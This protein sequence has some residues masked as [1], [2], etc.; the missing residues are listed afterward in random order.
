[1]RAELYGS[2]RIFIKKNFYNFYYSINNNTNLW[3]N[4]FAV[5]VTQIFIEKRKE[6]GAF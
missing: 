3:Y 5:F 2:A 1:M 4:F 6:K